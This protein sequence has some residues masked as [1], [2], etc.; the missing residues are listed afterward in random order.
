MRQTK[1]MDEAGIGPESLLG[2]VRFR[3]PGSTEPLFQEVFRL[4]ESQARLVGMLPRQAWCEYA[5]R[6]SILAAVLEPSD[7]SGE[8]RLLGY[9]AFRLPRDEVVLAHLV[10]S[11]SARRMGI[12]RLL[13]EQLTLR[14]A[15][16]R[17]IAARCRRD[18]EANA[19]WPHL[20][21]IALAERPGRSR[22]GHPL[23]F[24]WKDH[25]HEDLMSWQGAAP[26]AVS[27]AIDMNVFLDLHGRMDTERALATRD[28]FDHQLE[29]RVQLLRQPERVPQHSPR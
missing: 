8:D 23:T 11:E 22:E 21:F 9:A 5:N 7:R 16:R 6:Q 24:W 3:T 25:G 1:E 12:A 20:N 4:G 14:F 2:R 29:G 10:V 13:V 26:S 19:M 15:D 18:Y 27:V 17:G 28:L